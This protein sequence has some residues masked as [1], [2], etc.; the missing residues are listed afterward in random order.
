MSIKNRILTPKTRF[1]LLIAEF[2]GTPDSFHIES[3]KLWA[4]TGLLA[5]PYLISAISVQCR[6]Y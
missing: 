5:A 1:L 2:S 6:L 4:F 3:T